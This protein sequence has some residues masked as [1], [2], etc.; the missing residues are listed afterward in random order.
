MYTLK[1]IKRLNKCTVMV[2]SKIHQVVIMMFFLIVA[3]PGVFC[4]SHYVIPTFGEVM[5]QLCVKAVA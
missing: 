3:L 1:Q 2:F 4:F 5:L